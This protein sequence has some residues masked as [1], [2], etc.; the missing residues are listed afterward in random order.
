MKLW[1]TAG[2]TA[3]ITGR[4]RGR[5]DDQQDESFQEPDLFDEISA[6]LKSSECMHAPLNWVD[7]RRGRWRFSLAVDFELGLACIGG[8]YDIDIHC[9]GE[10]QPDQ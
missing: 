10:A 2:S 4:S 6:K 5:A 7:K 9:S 3:L 1:H 8:L